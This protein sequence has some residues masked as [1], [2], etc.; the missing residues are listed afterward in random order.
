MTFRRQRETKAKT[1]KSR[2]DTRPLRRSVSQI[3][4]VTKSG[5]RPTNQARILFD[6]W[7][8]A[9]PRHPLATDPVHTLPITLEASG[10]LLHILDTRHELLACKKPVI[11]RGAW[12]TR[13]TFLWVALLVVAGARLHIGKGE[14]LDLPY[15]RGQPWRRMSSLPLVSKHAAISGWRENR[16]AVEAWCSES[17]WF[18]LPSP[19]SGLHSPCPCAS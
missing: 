3:Q 17:C 11:G 4:A 8:P 12:S 19:C 15:W 13:R 5:K 1:Q 9:A 14:S 18:C 10:F 16:L 7:R 2:F 6:L